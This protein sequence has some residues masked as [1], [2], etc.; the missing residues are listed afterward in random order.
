VSRFI[1]YV[2]S[3]TNE[4]FHG[5]INVNGE[6]LMCISLAKFLNLPAVASEVQENNSKIFKNLL[7]IFNKNNRYAFPIDEFFGVTSL[8][9]DE[10]TEPPLTVAKAENTI[11]D[12]MVNY[13]SKTIAIINETKL[14]T[15]INKKVVW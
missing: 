12:S 10:M 9:N 5:I 15:V 14:F 3:R 8:S 2:P 11:T 6:L 7:I 1:H 13:K 4:F